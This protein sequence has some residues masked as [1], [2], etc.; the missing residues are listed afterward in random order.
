MFTYWLRQTVAYYLQLSMSKGHEIAAHGLAGRLRA[1]LRGRV[2]PAREVDATAG[3][4]APGMTALSKMHAGSDGLVHGFYLQH[5]HCT[6]VQCT[7]HVHRLHSYHPAGMCQLSSCMAVWF[8][9]TALYKHTLEGVRDVREWMAAAYKPELAATL[10]SC[11]QNMMH[12]LKAGPEGQP[13]V[14]PAS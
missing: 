2:V 3:Q 10:G 14:T 8:R 5:V 1:S 9:H 12:C 7:C 13:N 11:M 6:K 4:V